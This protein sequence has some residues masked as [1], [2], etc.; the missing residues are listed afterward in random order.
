MKA[1]YPP[2]ILLITAHSLRNRF[3]GL[4]SSCVRSG[5]G[6]TGSVT[7]TQSSRASQGAER[8][9][10][11]CALDSRIHDF[12]LFRSCARVVQFIFCPRTDAH[13]HVTPPPHMHRTC[14]HNTHTHTHTHTHLTPPKHAHNARTRAHTHTHAYTHTRGTL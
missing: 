4:N 8:R 3:P 5:Y 1:N 6:H 7:R 9:S 2:F 11:Q 10:H 12:L 14:A 13:V